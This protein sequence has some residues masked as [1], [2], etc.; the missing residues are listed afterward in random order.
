MPVVWREHTKPSCRACKQ[1]LVPQ[2]IYQI[3]WIDHISYHRREIKDW[4]IEDTRSESEKCVWR[5]R[6]ESLVHELGAVQSMAVG[7]TDFEGLHVWQQAGGPLLQGGHPVKTHRML[8]PQV[9]CRKW[10]IKVLVCGN[11]LKGPAMMRHPLGHPQT[12]AC[13]CEREAS[14]IYLHRAD[15]ALGMERDGFCIFTSFDKCPMNTCRNNVCPSSLSRIFFFHS[16]FHPLPLKCSHSVF[17]LSFLLSL[18]ESFP[19]SRSVCHRPCAQAFQS[20]Q[21]VFRFGFILQCQ[22]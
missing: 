20:W 19:R 12:F 9:H 6:Y 16:L 2:V 3:R 8:Y 7:C 21:N 11:R 10:A 22:K 4:G 17:S 5:L 14:T 13:R 18:S 15:C 1:I